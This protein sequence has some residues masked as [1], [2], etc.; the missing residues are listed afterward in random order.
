MTRHNFVII[1]QLIKYLGNELL[2]NGN[3][4]VVQRAPG[5]NCVN[6]H[7]QKSSGVNT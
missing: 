5:R 6:T 7:M 1:N 2:R 3:A 4:S